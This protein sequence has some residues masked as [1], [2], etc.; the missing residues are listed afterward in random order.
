MLDNNLFYQLT[1]A[2]LTIYAL[3][4][5]STIPLGLLIRKLLQ[6]VGVDGWQYAGRKIFCSAFMIVLFMIAR[7]AIYFMVKLDEEEFIRNFG[8]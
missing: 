7:F 6:K 2:S 4:M 8:A 1:I 3:P 5:I